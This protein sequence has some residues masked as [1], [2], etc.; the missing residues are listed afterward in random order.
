ML[1]PPTNEFVVNIIKETINLATWTKDPKGKTTNDKKSLVQSIVPASL[2]SATLDGSTI[3]PTNRD[4]ASTLGLSLDFCRRHVKAATPKRAALEDPEDNTA[5]HLQVLK[6]KGWT[7]IKP[8]VKQAMCSFTR[9][10]K[11]IVHSPLKNDAVLVPDPNDPSKKTRKK[12]C[13]FKFPFVSCTMI[14]LTR[15]PVAKLKMGTLCCL[16]NFA[17]D[18]ARRSAEND[19]TLQDCVCTHHLCADE[20]ASKLLQPI[21]VQIAQANEQRNQFGEG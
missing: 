21:Q 8:D 10:C 3:K 6:S 11:H 12:S 4:M 7:R 18:T 1:P 17:D 14:S 20:I 2:A 13:C 9:D 5:I 19:F 16:A 15:F